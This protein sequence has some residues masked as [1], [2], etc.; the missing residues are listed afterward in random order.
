MGKRC[1]F[2]IAI[3]PPIA[4]EAFETFETFKILEVFHRN[5]FAFYICDSVLY[6][7]ASIQARRI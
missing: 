5:Y 7:K 2:K 4:S 3:K 6:S 1:V